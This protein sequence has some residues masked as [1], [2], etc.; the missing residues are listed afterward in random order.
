MVG[1]VKPALLAG[2][3][4]IRI[5]WREGQPWIDWCYLGEKRL[6]EPFFVLS[7]DVQLQQPFK[8]LFRHQTT[9]DALAELQAGRPGL[10]P[11]GF[12]FHLSRCGSTLISQ[13]L[14]SLPQNIVI[15]EASCIDSVLR[16]N[17]HDPQIDEQQRIIWLQGLIGAL[18][19][20][21]NA[22][23]HFFVKFDSWHTLDL[24]LIRRAF[25]GVPWVFIC[26]D[27][28]AVIVSNMRQL[29]GHM[30]GGMIETHLLGVDS[31]ARMQ[32]P[33]EEFIARAL[34]K[35]CQTA[36]EQ[37]E[38]GNGRL[39]NYRQLPDFV[40]SS[41]PQIFG[42]ACTEQDREQMQQVS[43]FDAKAPDLVF[44]GDSTAKQQQASEFVRRL[45]DQWVKPLYEQLE[46]LRQI[47]ER[48]PANF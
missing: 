12:I 47:Q 14:A 20:Q 18:G 23:Q 45:S 17:Y 36:L 28:V 13:M 41:L 21:R 48:K 24:P 4:P 34:A 7:I 9:M 43:R 35:F 39:I 11:T 8:L 33:H 38:A 42:F 16:S 29:A 27:P 44:T 2:W 6:T 5:Y 25:P 22:E 1:H 26:R 40:W 32:M 3:I 10:S 19:Q 30:L 31:V 15:S 37:V 46:S